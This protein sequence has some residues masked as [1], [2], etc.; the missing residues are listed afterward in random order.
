MSDIRL[1][2][3]SLEAVMEHVK[4]RDPE[5]TEFHQAVHE[6]MESV[7]PF[8]RENKTYREP[9]LIERLLTYDHVPGTLGRPRR[10]FPCKPA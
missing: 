5:Q 4:N 6:V 3:I 8:I 7:V 10:E 1:G 2:S 9:G